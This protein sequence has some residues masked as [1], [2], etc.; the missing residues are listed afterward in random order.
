VTRTLSVN[1]LEENVDFTIIEDR[2]EHLD[3]L[4]EL[5]QG[6][7]T[8]RV[9]IHQVEESLQGDILLINVLLQLI[10]NDAYI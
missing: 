8:V 10:L 4:L 5:R 1:G 9:R 6:Y 7:L 3:L 2:S